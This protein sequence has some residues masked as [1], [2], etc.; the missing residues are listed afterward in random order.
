[1]FVVLPIVIGRGVAGIARE[2]VGI[3]VEWTT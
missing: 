3:R 1:L 2:S